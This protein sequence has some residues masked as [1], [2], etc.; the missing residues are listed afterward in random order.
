MSRIPNPRKRLS[1]RI[2]MAIWMVCAIILLVAGIFFYA[3]EIQQHQERIEQAKILLQSVYQHKRE[4][5]ANE[6]FA[7]HREALA[8]TLSEI[9]A[10]KGIGSVQ[11]FDLQG[12]ML[13]TEGLVHLPELPPD[14]R[15]RLA[16]SAFF[17]ELDLMHGPHIAY[18]TS[19]EVIGERLGYFSVTFDLS[20]LVSALRFR[21]LLFFLVFSSMLVVLS[22][23]LHL[24]LTRSVIRP[25]S[26]L[27]DAMGQV[28]KGRLDQSVTLLRSD[29]IGEM[30]LAFNA[31]AAQLRE[32]HERLIRSM[33]SRDTYAVQLE[34]TNRQLAHL[35][36]DLEKI[37]EERTRELR[38]SYEQLQAETLERIRADEQRRELEERLTRSQKMEALGLLAGGVAHDLNNVLSGIVSY[39]ELML[40]DLPAGDPLRKLV[41][42]IQRSGQKAAAIVQDLL[43]LARRGVMQTQVLNLN[44]EVLEDYLDSPE[45]NKLRSYYPGVKVEKRLAADLMNI[46]GSPVHLKKTVMNLV[47]NAAEAQPNGGRIVISTE[48]RYIDR[49]LGVYDRVTQGDYVVLRVEDHGTGI[50]PEDLN[51][52]FEPFYT[53]KVMGRSGTGLGMAV[54]WGTVH[55]HHGYINVESRLGEGTALE[56]YFP[57]T[58][59]AAE[60]TVIAVCPA[61]YCGRG[62]TVLVI[63][64]VEE[65]RHIASTL[66][67]RLNYRVVTVESGEAA[68]AY[69]KHHKADILVLDMIMDPGIDGLETYRRIVRMHPGQKCV[70]ASGFAENE[71]VK[72]AQRRGAGP[73]IRKPYTMEKIGLALRAELDRPPASVDIPPCDTVQDSAS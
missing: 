64:D 38:M 35:N 32:Q 30:A 21:I 29:E 19:I 1:L 14:V 69:L 59:L 44:R 18:N 50:A 27:R 16:Q 26:L 57:V 28:M 23:L 56:L 66:L 41:E 49:P 25:V 34:E 17:E 68:A 5:L 33:K 37:V 24:L 73:Y 22:I 3:F 67:T 31:M 47:S 71:R 42:G 45:F 6:I 65:Q 54:V 12:R 61:D 15:E 7:G 72:E 63:D 51:R 10:V 40:M 20:S 55:D 48:N 53:K 4:E 62:E 46:L 43:A 13:E 11:V 52:I 60:S 58:R 2:N 70:I 9:G 8:Y 36:T 39:P